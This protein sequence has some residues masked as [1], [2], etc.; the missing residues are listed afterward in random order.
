MALDISP[1][2][3]DW[4]YQPGQLAA[5]KIRGMDGRDKIQLRLDLGLLQMETSGRPDGA[6]PRGCESLLDHY[7]R[8]CELHRAQHGS[9]DGFQVDAEACDQLRNEAMLYYHRYV[10]E[11]VLEDFPAVE[12]DTSR[13]LRLLDFC[14]AHAAA[15]ADQAA[16][17]PHRA[18]IMMMRTRARC[19]QHLAA[20]R[21]REALEAV[22]QGIREIKESNAAAGQDSA[23]E[24]SAELAMLVELAEEVRS[25]LPVDPVDKLKQALAE[26]IAEERYEEA[27]AIRD[28]LRRVGGDSPDPT[29]PEK[30]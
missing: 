16:M 2:L 4:P 18:Y 9:A 7:E 10:A 5:R 21:S 25:H 8:Q 19:Q 23:G 1:I 12:R 30:P 3:K 17:E 15:P 24:Q 28:R 13:N 29:P 14:A 26:A 22:E 20:S 27:A 6:R 11:F